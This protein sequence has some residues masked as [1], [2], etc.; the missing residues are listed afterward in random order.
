[1][2]SGSVAKAAIMQIDEQFA[3]MPSSPSGQSSHAS[4]FIVSMLEDMDIIISI[5]LDWT[6]D[7]LNPTITR[8]A[9]RTVAKEWRR[10]YFISKT[11]LQ[12]VTLVFFLLDQVNLYPM[13][14]K[15]IMKFCSSERG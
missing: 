11:M 1:M 9:S 13:T 3:A 2:D 6:A 12:Q 8:T 14:G 10:L 5:V 7:R 4:E 15:T